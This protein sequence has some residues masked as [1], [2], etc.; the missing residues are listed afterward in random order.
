VDTI[1]RDILLALRTQGDLADPIGPDW[2]R[3]AAID[4]TSL[5]SHMVLVLLVAVVAG[6]L[7]CSGR[8]PRAALVIGAAAGAMLL[9]AGLKFL[10]A[11]A[12]PDVV[13]RLV[14]VHSASF[15]SGHA[16]L[17]AAIY[18]M[19]GALLARELSG[20]ARRYVMVVAVLLTLLIGLSRVYLGVHWPS[21][22]LAGWCIGALWAWGC[23]KLAQQLE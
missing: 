12:R 19:L 11:R 13:E 5:G 22:V 6:F 16:L 18:L 3:R 1:D 8:R 10:F 14:G 15:P 7:L 23:S 2:L 9:S 17:S 4:L 21:D 20:A